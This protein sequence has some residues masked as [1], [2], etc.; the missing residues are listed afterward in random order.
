MLTVKRTVLL[1]DYLY[2]FY[3]HNL[4]HF[5]LHIDRCFMCNNKMIFSPKIYKRLKLTLYFKKWKIILHGV[6]ASQNDPNWVTLPSGWR[7]CH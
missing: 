2:H 7:A 5:Y 6:L 4:Y 1:A 3:L